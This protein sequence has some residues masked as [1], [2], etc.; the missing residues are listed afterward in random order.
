LRGRFLASLVAG[1]GKVYSVNEEG[2]VFVVDASKGVLLAQLALGESC[3][4]T[5]ALADGCLF[6]RTAEHLHCLAGAP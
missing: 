6:V 2:S 5:P 4:A 3:A 1:D